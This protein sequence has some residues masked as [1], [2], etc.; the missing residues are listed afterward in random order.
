MYGEAQLGGEWF[1]ARFE[2]I[3]NNYVRATIIGSAKALKCNIVGIDLTLPKDRGHLLDEPEE[4]QSLSKVVPYGN[5]IRRKHKRHVSLVP[6]SDTLLPI[7][8]M[9]LFP[10]ISET[11]VDLL[12]YCLRKHIHR[13]GKVDVTWKE[14]SRHSVLGFKIYQQSVSDGTVRLMTRANFPCE[15]SIVEHVLRDK[16][17]VPGPFEGTEILRMYGMDMT[18]RREV[19]HNLL[20]DIGVCAAREAIFYEWQLEM[21][22]SFFNLRCSLIEG[23]ETGWGEVKGDSDNIRAMYEPG[24]GYMYRDTGNETTEFVSMLHLNPGGWVAY[25]SVVNSYQEQLF[26]KMEVFCEKVLSIK[27]EQFVPK[28]AGFGPI[29]GPGF[30]IVPQLAIMPP[31]PKIDLSKPSDTP[32][33]FN[34]NLPKETDEP[35]VF[36]VTN[37]LKP[38]TP[39]F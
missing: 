27:E 13:A 7:Q 6:D 12:D 22:N 24:T 25:L 19:M 9:K 3:D 15:Y 28:D 34:F 33:S 29:T 31:P 30:R 17:L 39:V 1:P 26:K 8:P 21:H 18:I 37:S 10:G 32:F 36:D 5:V 16:R 2:E 20:T 14:V 11:Q 38:Y 35:P 23:D 4:M